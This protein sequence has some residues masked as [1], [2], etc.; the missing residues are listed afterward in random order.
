MAPSRQGDASAGDGPARKAAKSW[1]RVQQNRGPGTVSIRCQ[2]PGA[3]AAGTR[4]S[5]GA[6]GRR[7]LPPDPVAGMAEKRATSTRRRTRRCR[8][9]AGLAYGRCSSGGRRQRHSRPGPGKEC[10]HATPTLTWMPGQAGQE[11]EPAARRHLEPHRRAVLPGRRPNPAKPLA[12][13]AATDPTADSTVQRSPPPRSGQAHAEWVDC[14]AG[15]H[16]KHRRHA[17]MPN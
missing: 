9:Q 13:P 12:E 5:P 17:L 4:R 11:A 16:W 15:P 8:V 10:G 7:R 3:R 2:R 1:R 6:A 14:R